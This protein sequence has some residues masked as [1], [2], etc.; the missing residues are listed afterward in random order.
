M[1]N[2]KVKVY[3]TILK[4]VSEKYEGIE[5]FI[6]SKIEEICSQEKLSGEEVTY[7]LCFLFWLLAVK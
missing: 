2:L 6:N 1:N 3:K 7:F 4:E 5:E